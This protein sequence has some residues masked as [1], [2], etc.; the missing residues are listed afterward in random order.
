[1]GC[2]KYGG[3]NEKTP[4][5][6]ATGQLASATKQPGTLFLSLIDIFQDLFL[7]IRAANGT[8]IGGGFQRESDPQRLG[9]LEQFQ[10]D[11][12]IDA[13]MKDE[14]ARGGAPLPR[15]SEGSEERARD[16]KLDIRI[17]HDDEG[18]FTLQFQGHPLQP[19]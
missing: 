3:V 1:M 4:V 12:I 7:L 11:F 10:E 8:Y 13:F 15:R 9:S 2:L 14:P 6:R 18:V 17:I 19:L 5:I 16:S